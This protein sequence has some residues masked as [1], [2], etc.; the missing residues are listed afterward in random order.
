MIGLTLLTHR[1]PGARVLAFAALAVALAMVAPA[2]PAMAQAENAPVSV[3]SRVPAMAPVVIDGRALFR[4]RGVTAYP[5]EE[6]ANAIAARIAAFA[7]DA[8]RSTDTL[9]TAEAEHGTDILAGDVPLM[10]VLDED[11]R[12]EGVSRQ[13]L[14]RSDLA[15]IARAVT[16]YRDERSASRLIR[17][18]LLTLAATAI[19]AIAAFLL[20]RLRRRLTDLVEH[21]YQRRV[22]QIEAGSFQL[23]RA[24]S[25]WRAAHAIVTTVTLLLAIVGF[26]SYLHFVLNLYPWTRGFADRLFTLL[27]GPV[28]GVAMKILLSIPDLI[29]I[30]IVVLAA[31]YLLRLTRLFFE[32]IGSGRIKLA[33]FEAEWAD[34]TLKI[35]RLLVVAFA[36]VVAYPYIPGSQS[37]AFKG[38]TIFFGVLF[39]LGSSSFI[40]NLIA[41]YT[42]TYRRAFHVGDRIA[43]GNT[44]GD[45][46]QVRLM[47][48]HLRS[49]KNEELIIPN[50][51]LLASEVTNFSSLTRE[52]GLILHTTVGI[53]YETPW[54]QV[55]AM[56]LM[57]AGRTAGVLSDPPPFVLQKGLGDFC[58]TYELNV[59]CDRP[60]EMYELYTE[61]HRAILD[62]FNEYGVQI[63][64]PAYIADPATPKMVPKEQWFAAPARTA[65]T[66]PVIKR[67]A[68]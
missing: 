30:A 31:G 47:V 13:I 59:Y 38:I 3:E 7:A 29:I 23:I 60:L 18:G 20:V 62:V 34:P 22:D 35:V 51:T 36:A 9:R 46:T 56:L 24:R 26:Y 4:V 40:A 63:M 5:A 37:A 44:I 57:A 49:L 43:I 58:V 50:S 32:A 10:S 11:A 55:E 39:S 45:V 64:T 2:V 61:L 66:T 6:R 25:I 27:L 67:R 19:A 68:I 21:R 16:A 41:G 15:A 28:G 1:L 12:I 8:S 33:N 42:M 53:G 52:K 48:T 14:A 65:D 17:D 54:R